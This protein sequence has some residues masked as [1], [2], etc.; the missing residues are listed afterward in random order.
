MAATSE[1]LFRARLDGQLNMCHQLI[2][3]AGLINWAS[4]ERQFCVHFTSECGRPTLPTRLV[5]GLLY[6]QHAND[7][8]DEAVVATQPLQRRV[9]D[10]IPRRS[11]NGAAMRYVKQG[12][13]HLTARSGGLEC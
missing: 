4:I 8:S 11:H 10:T 9:L 12:Q 6:L 7:A 13:I 1:E 2:R 3:L 5:A